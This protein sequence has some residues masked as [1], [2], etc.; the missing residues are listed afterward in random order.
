MKIYTKTGDQGET[1]L[2]D[3][4][5]VA[6]DHLRLTVYGV[7]DEANSFLGTVLA[8]PDLPSELRQRLTRV[9]AELFQLGSELATPR[10]RDVGIECVGTEQILALESEI[11]QMESDLPKLTQ[12]ILPGGSRASALL[13]VVRSVIR[14][15]ERNL[16][17]LHR[18]EPLRTEVLTY[19]NRLSDYFFVCARWN[20]F[21]QGKTE[22]PW[23]AT[24]KKKN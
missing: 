24:K 23:V 15:A 10:G 14:R 20:N 4:K 11:D 6:K 8:E 22:T 3:G 17:V 16:V 5:R 1:S 9:Q 18:S 19:I 13:H 21:K 12:F 7:T 2:I